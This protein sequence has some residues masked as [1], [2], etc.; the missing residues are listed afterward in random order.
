MVRVLHVVHGLPDGGLENGVVNLLNLLPVDEFSQAVCCL[1]VRGAMAERVQRDIPIFELH[2]R[3]HDLGAPL[4]LA[5]VLRAW[6]PDIVHCRNWNTWPDTVMA[7]VLSGRRGELVWSFHGFADQPGLPT[8][9]RIASRWLAQA[10]DAMF[11]VCQD[12][13]RRYAAACGIPSSRFRVLHNGVD[14]ERFHPVL[15]KAALRFELGL[16]V[17]AVL[18]V[19]VA[20]FTPIKN[21]L[22]LLEAAAELEAHGLR[23]ISYALIGDGPLRA[24]LEG[25]VRTLNLSHRVRFVGSTGRVEAYLAAAD[26]FI[27]PSRLEGMS[28][29]ILEAMACGVPVIAYHV[30]GNP[31]LV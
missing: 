24:E 18:A 23:S 25:R 8:R 10:T 9:R 19:T 2:R 17:E 28:N 6:R 4:R 1:D 26:L 30:G 12:S 27:L 7:H 20:S 14:C 3:R 31:E 11:A 5:R 22:A 15:D 16:P 29:A 13:A 21:H